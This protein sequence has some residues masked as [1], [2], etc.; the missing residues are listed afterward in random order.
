MQAIGGG[1]PEG[2]WL[3]RDG[4]GPV[5]SATGGRRA[6]YGEHGNWVI[7]APTSR[8]TRR[9]P[10][11][12]RSAPRDCGAAAGF[13]GHPRR[14]SR[15]TRASHSVALVLG[16]RSP[17]R[18]GHG[19]LCFPT[20]HGQ[21][22]LRGQRGL[23]GCGGGVARP[24]GPDPGRSGTHRPDD[25]GRHDEIHHL[26]PVRPDQKRT[27]VHA[28][29][30]RSHTVAMTGDSV[31]D[32]S[33]AQGRPTSAW[34]WSAAGIAR[35]GPD[36]VAGQQVRHAVLRGRR[37]PAG[38][39]QHERVS[40]LFLPR[41]SLVLLTLL[42]GLAALISHFG[43][44]DPL[45]Y[46]FQPSSPSPPGSPSESWPSSVAGAQHERARTGFVCRVTSPRHRAPSSGGPRFL[47]CLPGLPG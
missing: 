22:D 31:N 25:A 6:S 23:G 27:M 30:S 15:R 13:V 10:G 43:H 21:G 47:S 36:R 46:P 42:V 16:S 44:T 39:R 20:C 28:L 3:D 11:G 5:Q 26:R 9:P 14:C 24:A 35:G 38:D 29:Q 12:R 2:P 8:R 41:P 45:C 17:G 1:L 40:N 32:V 4:N 37:G 33:R 34:R 19:I 7:G 18:P